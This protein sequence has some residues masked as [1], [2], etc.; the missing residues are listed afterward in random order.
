MQIC[1]SAST[2][3]FWWL[4]FT[5]WRCW[6]DDD[7][8]EMVRMK[9]LPTPLWCLTSQTEG[10]LWEQSS[11]CNLLL[12]FLSLRKSKNCISS[13]ICTFYLYLSSF[14]FSYLYFGW[15]WEQSSNCNLL[16]FLSQRKSKDF[17]SVCISI[18]ISAFLHIYIHISILDG[19]ERKGSECNLLLFFCLRKWENWGLRTEKEP[20]LKKTRP[21]WLFSLAPNREES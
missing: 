1:T 18:C 4:L 20:C 17:S 6:G 2:V 15:L 10:W 21:F 8:D 19:F 16:L 5:I 7:D 14:F 3:A 11:N 12:F 9:L 13:C